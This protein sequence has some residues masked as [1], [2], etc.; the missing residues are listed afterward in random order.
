MIYKHRKPTKDKSVWYLIPFSFLGKASI[1]IYLQND[2]THD[3]I[4][5][6]DHWRLK[7]ESARSYA[8]LD[9]LEDISDDSLVLIQR[10]TK[11]SNLSK[12]ATNT[13]ALKESLNRT[14]YKIEE[15]H[16][17]LY[18][19]VLRGKHLS[20]AT[21]KGIR[22]LKITSSDDGVVT[23]GR[24][25][26]DVYN[27]LNNSLSRWV[28][29]NI[30]DRQ[31]HFEAIK[32]GHE[33]LEDYVNNIRKQLEGKL[34]LH[35][36]DLK[37]EAKQSNAS[38]K[39]YVNDLCE[40]CSEYTTH[41]NGLWE[42]FVETYSNIAN[43]K[44]AAAEIQKQIDNDIRKDVGIYIQS[45][46]NG[47]IA[48]TKKLD[49][50]EYLLEA[51]TDEHEGRISSLEIQLSEINGYLLKHKFPDPTGL[52]T[53]FIDTDRD[54][55][56]FEE[57]ILRNFENSAKE[58]IVTTR[59]RDISHDTITRV[60][61]DAFLGVMR[62]LIGFEEVKPF[63]TK[64]QQQEE[65]TQKKKEETERKAS[66]E[67]KANDLKN[68]NKERDKRDKEEAEA[69][70]N[71]WFS[72]YYHPTNDKHVCSHING[73]CDIDGYNR[74]GNNEGYTPFTKPEW[75]EE[76]RHFD[77]KFYNPEHGHINGY[78]DGYDQ[79]GYSF[80]TKGTLNIYNRE[81][82]NKWGQHQ[83]TLTLYN[84]EGFN[85]KGYNR[86]GFNVNGFNINGYDSKGY[87]KKGYNDKGWNAKHEHHVTGRLF[88][89]EGYDEEGYNE[90]HIDKQG[91]SKY[92]NLDD[93]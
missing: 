40:K 26:G 7:V 30:N 10:D 17:I 71:K 76:I 84:L 56:K 16:D 82:W 53:K 36:D 41:M 13:L 35:M 34:D 93:L 24:R 63:K 68:K 11:I 27:K 8:I 33:S 92:G 49:K 3:E 39:Q 77:K 67:R 44:E 46:I 86:D 87:N 45:E 43:F 75:G 1:K 9:T 59:L 32:K 6:T 51:N 37:A 15:L 14:L 12:G 66:E 88:D 47:I 73:G 83:V 2:K 62:K 69:A 38:L 23:D 91:K 29:I 28:S 78:V 50:F 58:E 70:E 48:V 81:G 74:A 72:H 89:P 21:G 18:N 54:T 85:V 57:R 60:E 5:I 61:A 22:V 25:L 52:F 19:V 90:W 80:P 79:N 4:D 42:K 31:K 65:E 20:V 55:E 64:Q